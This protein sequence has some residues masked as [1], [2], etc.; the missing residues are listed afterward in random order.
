VGRDKLL[1]H[2]C[3]ERPNI[4]TSRVSASAGDI[5]HPKS[6]VEPSRKTPILLPATAQEIETVISAAAVCL[7]TPGKWRR[8]HVK[9][10]NGMST[11]KTSS[12]SVG[13]GRH[14]K[15]APLHVSKSSW[16]RLDDFSS[17]PSH[18]LRTSSPK[19]S[20]AP[21]DGLLIPKRQSLPVIERV[22]QQRVLL[23]RASSLGMTLPL[24]IDSGGK[25]QQERGRHGHE[26][27]DEISDYS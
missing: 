8:T 16:P 15:P 12:K 1:Q 26:D 22:L 13:G 10:L 18:L 20:A 27:K 23:T 25:R 6:L 14:R 5:R 19:R 9:R 4:Q 11:Q 17:Q 21:F 2:M 7:S 24:N 3:K